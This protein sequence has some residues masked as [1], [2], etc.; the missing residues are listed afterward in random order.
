MAEGYCAAGQAVARLYEAPAW[1]LVRS[2]CLGWRRN[3]NKYNCW[4]GSLVEICFEDRRS[5]MA[6]V[7]NNGG[8]RAGL[9]P[10][11]LRRSAAPLQVSRGVRIEN[12]DQQS[13]HA[14]VRLCLR[15]CM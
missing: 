4:G 14:H 2:S 13:K 6:L 11:Q 9:G 7:H 15:M 8:R 1:T 10:Q 3:C 5:F 12:S